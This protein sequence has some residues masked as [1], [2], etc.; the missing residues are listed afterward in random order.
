MSER[1]IL[2][3]VPGVL[4]SDRSAAR[5]GG[6]PDLGTGA[7]VS[8]VRFF[9][10]VALGFIRRLF[11]VAGARVVVSDAW[12]R[13]THAAI[14]QQL[15]L[16]VEAMLPKAEG[17]FGAEIDAWYARR[18]AASAQSCVIL[19]CTPVAQL[20]AGMRDRAIQVDPAE[21]MTVANFR[22]ALDLLGVAC[23]SPLLPESTFDA[24]LKARLRTLQQLARVAPARYGKPAE[25]AA[26]LEAAMAH[27]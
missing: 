13:G 11:G 6:R 10:P 1:L 21:G 24:E 15:D 3:D 20:P 12:R 22:Q 7:K 4:F 17:G 26:Q 23:P 18:G 27:A 25:A 8:E 19:T 9:D 14:L 2:L 5:L 16:Q